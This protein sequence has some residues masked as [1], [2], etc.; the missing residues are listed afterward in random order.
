MTVAHRLYLF[1]VPWTAKTY[2][3]NTH[4]ER[5]SP[6]AIDGDY[7]TTFISRNTGKP[8]LSVDFGATYR[9]TKVHILLSD[10]LDEMHLTQNL[11]VKISGR[12]P[13]SPKDGTHLGGGMV[14]DGENR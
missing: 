14:L 3:E 12:N 6:S 11:E 4:D 8:W 5:K 1:V 13:V 7:D 10:Q 9:V 2:S